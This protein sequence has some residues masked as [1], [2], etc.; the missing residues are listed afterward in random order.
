MASIAAHRLLSVAAELFEVKPE[1]IMSRDR[2]APVAA[3]RQAMAWALV[4]SGGYAI[5]QVGKAL[6][7]D[8]KAIRHAVRL[9]DER[10]DARHEKLAALARQWGAGCRTTGTD[11]AH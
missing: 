9:V 3:A 8:K 11:G 1:E 5:R 10:R 6:G 2:T 4:R 7:R